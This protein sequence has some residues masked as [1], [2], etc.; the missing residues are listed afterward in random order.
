LQI[1][2]VDAGAFVCGSAGTG[3]YD[4]FFPKEGYFACK[5][6]KTPLY[7]SQSKF[8]SG[9]AKPK[10]E[11]NKKRK[12]QNLFIFI[13]LCLGGWPAFDK[14][15]EGAIATHTDSSFGMKRVEIVCA[16]CGAHMG[17]VF[18]GE[19]MTDTNERHCVN[20]ISTVF[21]KEAPKG[22]LQEKKVL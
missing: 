14:C 4:K 10:K 20:S 5:V 19:H 9:C 8:D 18:E 6:C 15:Y 17:H 16:T 11:K 12:S 21:V 2:D 13:L 3:E 22:D 7:S 1:L